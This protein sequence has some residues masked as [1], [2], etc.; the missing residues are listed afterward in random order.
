MSSE[1]LDPG[2]TPAEWHQAICQV[3]G[4]RAN[5]CASAIASMETVD[6]DGATGYRDADGDS[7]PFLGIVADGKIY[8]AEV[9][10]GG[11]GYTFVM[12]GHVDR[13]MFDAFLATVKLPVIPALER[14]YTS[15]LSGYSIKYPS[16]WAV[17]PATRPWTVGY[18]TEHYSDLIGDGFATF[19]GA[20]M[21]LPAGMPF[22]TWFA[23]YDADRTRTNC[24]NPTGNE[25]VTV[26]GVVGHLDVHCPNEY[27]RGGH[28]EGRT[29]LRPDDVPAVQQAFVRSIARHGPPDPGDRNAL[30]PCRY[31]AGL[32]G[33]PIADHH[34][35]RPRD[36]HR[37]DDRR[38]RPAVRRIYAEGIATGDATLEP[39]RPSGNTSTVAPRGLPVRRA[40]SGRTAGRRLDG[41]RAATRPRKVYAGSPGRAS[42]SP[43]RRAA[44][45]SARPARGAHPGLGGGRQLDAPRGVLP[46]TGEPRPPRAGG[47]R[48]VGVQT[49]R[50]GCPRPL[51]R[52]RPPRAA[53]RDR[54]PLS[55]RPER[56]A[57]T[58]RHSG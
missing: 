7:E 51:A 19:Y 52:R 25:D 34:R 44:E 42:T 39:R 21:K 29:R 30:R 6:V 2:Q 26:D 54:R 16:A 40:R 45:A 11:R 49:D 9:V 43:R 4:T 56:S 32:Q 37:A 15:A 41:A 57:T 31:D 27:L 10:G 35:P 48:R 47:F 1:A 23:A 13:G 28:P 38:R 53:E 22:E 18:Y 12:D 3:D 8:G 20:S 14:T 24:A 36:Q 55:R 5:D 46:R 58:S 17:T 50:P 33:S